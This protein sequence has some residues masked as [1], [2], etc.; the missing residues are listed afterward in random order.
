MRLLLVIQDSMGHLLPSIR[1]GQHAQALGHQVLAVSSDRHMAIMDQFGVE[2]VSVYNADVPFLSTR[3]WYLVETVKTQVRVLHEVAERF[4]PDAIVCGPLAISAFIMAEQLDL[5]VG[6]I[7]YSTLLYPGLGDDDPT[8]RWRIHSITGFYNEARRALGLGIVKP[9]PVTTPLLGDC[10]MI[11]NVAE[12]T[13][14]VR[15]HDKIL[16]VGGLNIEPKSGHAAARHFARQWREAGR[17]VVFVQLGRLFEKQHIWHRLLT[18][19]DA[20]GYAILADTGRSDYLPDGVDVPRHCFAARFLCLGDVADLVDAVICSGHSASLIGAINHR[21]PMAFL[22][23]S[24]DSVELATRAKQCGLG[25]VI[26][27]K[28]SAADIAADLHLFFRRQRAGAFDPAL[29][30]FAEQFGQARLGERPLVAEVLG[31]LTETG[32]RTM[33]ALHGHMA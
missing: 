31:R 27:A 4:R 15:L 26:D 10:W 14:D 16:H 18:A 3:D 12:F 1:F 24:A 28:Q 19:L 7:G 33:P 29:A 5:P 21:L 32:R 23:T 9:D 20:Q 25:A 13:G 22:P 6:I 2:H 30:G 17:S 8:R 11:R